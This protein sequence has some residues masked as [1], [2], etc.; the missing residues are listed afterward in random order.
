MQ[1]QSDGLGEVSQPVKSFLA[2][3]ERRAKEALSETKNEFSKELSLKDR[4]EE[5]NKLTE[6]NFKDQ[7]LLYRQGFF[8]YLLVMMAL[9]TIVLFTIVILASVAT[10]DILDINDTTLQVLVGATI[11]QV[12]TML[13]V[14]IKSVYSDNL[15]EL[16]SGD[17][18]VKRKEK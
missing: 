2:D 17:Y 15:L 13:I 4:F 5:Q 16:Y 10:H 1:G 7:I 3:I 6:Q 14:I 9:E 12:S 11:A 18:K 8:V